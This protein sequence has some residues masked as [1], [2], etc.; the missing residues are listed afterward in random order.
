MRRLFSSLSVKAILCNWRNWWASHNNTLYF[1]FVHS[2]YLVLAVINQVWRNL[3]NNAWYDMILGVRVYVFC[4]MYSDACV[5]SYA[6][7]LW[8]SKT[9]FAFT[10]GTK[11]FT[12]DPKLLWVKELGTSQ[13]KK[14][15]HVVLCNLFHNIQDSCCAGL[16]FRWSDVK[17][18]I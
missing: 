16:C 4:M 12:L 8:A 5:L 3:I 1:A 2:Y 6:F 18:W 14:I 9:Q 15:K 13:G 17:G 7:L 11:V 10:Y